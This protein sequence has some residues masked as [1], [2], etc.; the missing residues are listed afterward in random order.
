MS[1]YS[2]SYKYKARFYATLDID[3]ETRKFIK[4]Y[5]KAKDQVINGERIY[6]VKKERK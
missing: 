1:I 3:K 5:N 6:F 2:N 4:T